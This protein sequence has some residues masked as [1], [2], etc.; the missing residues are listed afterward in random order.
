MASAMTSSTAISRWPDRKAF[1]AWCEA[2]GRTAVPASGETMAEWVQHLTVTPRKRTGAPA[3]P[4]TV[5]R[6]MSAVTT[7]HEE[8]GHPKP[9]MRGARA[10]LNAYKDRLAEEKAEAAQ[11]RQVTAALPLQIRAMLAGNDR[12]ALVGK[13]NAAL[14]LLGFATAARVSELGCPGPGG[15]RGSRARLRRD[16]VQEEGAQAHRERG[17]VRH[18]PGHLPRPRTAHLPRCPRGR[19]T[20]RGPLCSSA[21]TGGTAWPRPWP[22]VAASSGTRPGG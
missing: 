15:R 11:A 1:E 9:N 22:G 5:E 18:R 4:S 16:R 17:P 13:R 12:S 2:E 21:S 7:W 8:Q 6:A 10:V 3:G 19:R 20:H 14:V